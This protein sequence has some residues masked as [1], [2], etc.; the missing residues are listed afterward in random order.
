MVTARRVR[1]LPTLPPRA[2]LAGGRGGLPPPL[3]RDGVT[4]WFSAR[5]ALFQ[6]IGVLGL[7]VGDAVALP[8]FACGSEV[9]PFLHGGLR[10][11]FFGVTDTLDPEPA[12]FRSA[13]EGAR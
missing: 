4:F 3:N 9:D 12:S 7:R 1:S 8:A 13:L 2:L 6:A 10:P 5:V 11:R